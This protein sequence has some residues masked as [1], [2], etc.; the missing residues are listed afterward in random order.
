MYTIDPDGLG[1][2]QVWCDMET[3]SGG[4]TVFQRR[5]DANTDFYRKWQEYKIG[6]GDMENNFWLGLNSLHR[7]TKSGENVLRVD[8]VDF[9]LTNAYAKYDVFIVASESEGYKLNLGSYSGKKK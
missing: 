3:D 8:L 5:Q 6:F 1:A 7:L 4:W 2:F 9:D